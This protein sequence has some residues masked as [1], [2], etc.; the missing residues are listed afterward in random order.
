[1]NA[2]WAWFLRKL[3]EDPKVQ[4]VLAR[5]RKR[6]FRNINRRARAQVM[7][8]IGLVKVRGALGGTYWE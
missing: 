3:S 8:D 2:D 4:E 7:K 1:M 6:R 5:E